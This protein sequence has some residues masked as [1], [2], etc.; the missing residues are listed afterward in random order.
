MPKISNPRPEDEGSS[1]LGGSAGP[2]TTREAP[3]S[4]L[5]PRASKPRSSNPRCSLMPMAKISHPRSADGRS[6]LL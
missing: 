3:G 2:R 6:G 5:E 4:A 1:L